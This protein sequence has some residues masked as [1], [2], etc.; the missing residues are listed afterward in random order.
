MKNLS[1]GEKLMLM[2]GFLVG[3]LH[4]AGLTEGQ[5]NNIHKILDMSEEKK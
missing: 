2:T 3:Q 1:D 4:W 5:R